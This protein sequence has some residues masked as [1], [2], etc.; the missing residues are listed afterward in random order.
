MYFFFL[1]FNSVLLAQKFVIYSVLSLSAWP[2]VFVKKTKVHR[3]IFNTYLTNG[4][5]IPDLQPN[6]EY[7]YGMQQ[8]LKFNV[9]TLIRLY[10]NTTRT[11]KYPKPSL[12]LLF[13]VGKVCF[14]G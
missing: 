4:F 2:F 13:V 10:I 9:I 1:V 7:Q 3:L 14:S 11:L 5:N 8:H 12:N 6:Y